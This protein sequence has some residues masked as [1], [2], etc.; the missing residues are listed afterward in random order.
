MYRCELSLAQATLF[1]V[2]LER[3]IHSLRVTRLP[4]VSAAHSRAYRRGVVSTSVHLDLS[5]RAYRR[6]V[7]AV[8]LHS[9]VHRYAT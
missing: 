8:W 4:R 9:D 7:L 3:A 5:S 6:G 2:F 1:Q